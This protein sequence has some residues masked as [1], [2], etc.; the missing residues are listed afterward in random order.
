ML[1]LVNHVQCLQSF[2][3]KIYPQRFYVG[4]SL[5]VP[6]TGFVG[7]SYMIMILC[8]SAAGSWVSYKYSGI[9]SDSA[10]SWLKN[11]GWANFWLRIWKPHHLTESHPKVTGQLGF[12]VWSS[13]G[14]GLRGLV[15]ILVC[16]GWRVG[17]CLAVNTTTTTLPI[18]FTLLLLIE[19]HFVVTT[20]GTWFSAVNSP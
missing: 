13:K 11:L 18:L 1:N 19:E 17:I 2:L 15:M 12:S 9:E 14:L 16:I 20:A 6:W 8:W 4:W 7:W 5:A 10:L 3:A